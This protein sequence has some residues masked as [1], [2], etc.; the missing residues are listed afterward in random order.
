MHDL[1]YHVRFE[2]E[3]T[4]L[5]VEGYS[6]AR[7]RDDLL[8]PHTIL[9]GERPTQELGRIEQSVGRDNYCRWRVA[10]PANVAGE[11]DYQS[12]AIRAVYKAVFP[13]R[14]L[15]CVEECEHTGDL[16]RA[17]RSLV[18]AGASIVASGIDDDEYET[19]W[20]EVDDPRGVEELEELMWQTPDPVRNASPFIFLS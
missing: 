7:S 14:K 10:S 20:I 17:E 9:R 6:E 12:D 11:Y 1:S 8:S 2:D 16:R 3:G 18:A 15:I 19:G 4:V 5:V 13:H